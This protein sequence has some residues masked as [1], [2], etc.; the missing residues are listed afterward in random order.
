MS[1]VSVC[2]SVLVLLLVPM[3]DLSA[4]TVSSKFVGA[5]TMVSWVITNAAGNESHPH[6][7]EAIR[8]GPHQ[9]DS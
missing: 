3:S 4:Q 2:V 1:K 6:G 7:P 5:W 8:G 9:L